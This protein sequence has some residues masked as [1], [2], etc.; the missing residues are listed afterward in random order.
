MRE[1]VDHTPREMAAIMSEAL[2]HPVAYRQVTIED[3]RAQFSGRGASPAATDAMVEMAQAQADGVYPTADGEG[4]GTT[5]E[6][7]C[8]TTLVRSL[9]LPR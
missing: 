6:T 2:G 1:P 8:Q 4:S 3:Y 9:A 5:F 7:W